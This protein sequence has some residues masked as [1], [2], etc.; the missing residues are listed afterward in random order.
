MTLQDTPEFNRAFNDLASLYNLTDYKDRRSR[1]FQVLN[2]LKIESLTQ[3]FTEAAKRAGVGPCRFFP[4][5]GTLR[6]LAT[7]RSSSSPYIN[8]TRPEETPGLVAAR[9]HFFAQFGRHKIRR[10]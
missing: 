9:A 7:D 10:V 3:A 4:L 5:T 6:E 2:D 8:P 1:Y